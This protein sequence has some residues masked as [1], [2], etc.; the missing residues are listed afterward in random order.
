MCSV[1]EKSRGMA[2]SIESQQMYSMPL[3]KAE[4]QENHHVQWSVEIRQ[5]KY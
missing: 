1:P 2:T 5:D 4:Q 3:K